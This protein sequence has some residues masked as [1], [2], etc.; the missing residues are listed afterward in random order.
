MNVER[1]PILSS[2]SYHLPIP[3][4]SPPFPP[5]LLFN[6]EIYFGAAYP[7]QAAYS[8]FLAAATLRVN[9]PAAVCLDTE[10]ALFAFWAGAAALKAQPTEAVV[11][12]ALK[13]SAPV[14]ERHLE[15]RKVVAQWVEL[16]KVPL[17]M[18]DIEKAPVTSGG[19]LGLLWGCQLGSERKGIEI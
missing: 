7:A 1:L 19:G 8:G 15:Q 11:S 9:W 4:L 18:G 6:A 3:S 14:S 5:P 16:T 13:V 17:A 2:D 12:V 10:A